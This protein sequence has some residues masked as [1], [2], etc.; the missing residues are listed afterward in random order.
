MWNTSFLALVYRGNP[1]FEE[2]VTPK[3]PAVQPLSPRATALPPF[4]AT[5]RQRGSPDSNPYPISPR[6]GGDAAHFVQTAAGQISFDALQP[7]PSGLSIESSAEFVK[8][9]DENQALA[10]K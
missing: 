7:S 4:P 9:K 8:L 5:H 2:P 3:S 1:L 6:A 10:D